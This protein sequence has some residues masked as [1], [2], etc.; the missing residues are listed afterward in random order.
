MLCRL[1]AGAVLPARTD[2]DGEEMLVLGGTARDALGAYPVGTWLRQP[3]GASPALAAATA[4]RVLIKRGHLS[5]P[6]AG[7]ALNRVATRQDEMETSA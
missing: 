4:C 7:P 2:H 5:R 6:P 1:D 3:P